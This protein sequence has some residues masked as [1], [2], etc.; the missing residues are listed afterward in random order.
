MKVYL[1]SCNV[2]DKGTML[3]QNCMDIVKVEPGSSSETCPASHNGNQITD[4]N[5]EPSGSQ[6][7]LLL[8]ALPGIEPEH[9]VSCMSACYAHVTSIQNCV[10]PF[11]SPPICLSTHMDHLHSTEQI[12]KSSLECVS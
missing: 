2:I 8:I 9:E 6:E 1:I 12:L 3:L 4:T 5:V 11:L 10:L 7:N